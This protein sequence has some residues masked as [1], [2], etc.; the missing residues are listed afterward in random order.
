MTTPQKTEFGK[1]VRDLRIAAGLRQRQCAEG[2]GIKPSTYANIESSTFRVIGEER[3][4]RI[5]E[6]YK[7]GPER[8]AELMAAWEATP[9]SPFAAK[10]K[11]GW[12]RRN[13]MRYKAKHHDRVFGSLVEVLGMLI[14][15]T[16][17][18]QVC[19]CELDG[20]LCPV[21]AALDHVGLSGFD[22]QDKTLDRLA[23]LT[24]KLA[25]RAAAEP[26]ADEVAGG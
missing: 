14:M 20:N 7:L 19:S 1:M 4:R 18:D 13:R 25:A 15:T 22:T 3:A 11:E 9:L 5:A 8:T 12:D 10:R 17:E 16:P 6:F 26:H 21:C 23:R 2:I 24:D